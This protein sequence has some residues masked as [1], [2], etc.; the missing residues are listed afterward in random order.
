MD[1]VIS[2]RV[3]KAVKDSAQEVA[4]STGIKLSTLI[5]AFLRQVAATRR[6]EFY[7]PEPM[8]PKLEGLIA[9]V[10]VE[11]EQGKISR[12]FTKSDD[13]VNDLQK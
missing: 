12:P 10:E 5:N 8:T 6:G 13:F 1:T 4:N 9:K 2:V 3:N 11:L 7:A